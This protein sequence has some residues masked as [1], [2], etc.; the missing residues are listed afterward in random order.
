MFL[1]PS[2]F[3]SSWFVVYCGAKFIYAFLVVS[4]YSCV[5]G[6]VSELE[7]IS[8]NISCCGLFMF[9]SCV[10]WWIFILDAQGVWMFAEFCLFCLDRRFNLV[11]YGPGRYVC[12]LVLLQVAKKLCLGGVLCL[13]L[14]VVVLG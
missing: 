6:M 1:V 9:L 2:S 11:L 5:F 8:R 12:F 3:F 4:D 13:C 7:F 10:C 14:G